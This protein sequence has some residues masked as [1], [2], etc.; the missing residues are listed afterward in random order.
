[1]EATTGPLGQ[2]IGNAVGIA[3]AEKMLSAHFNT[4]N[5][6]IIDHYTYVLASDGDMMEGIS[7]EA[8]SLAGHLGLGKLLI[9]YDSNKITID[10]SID[11]S[12]TEDISR[13]FEAMH[14]HTDMVDGYALDDILQSINKAKEILDRPSLIILKTIIAKGAPSLAGK[15]KAHSSPLG[16]EEVKNTKKAMGIN[17]HSEFYIDQKAITYFS[18]KQNLWAAKYKEW[19]I[20]FEKWKKEYPL[21]YAEWEKYYKAPDLMSV[22]FPVFKIGVKLSVRAASG[23]VLNALAQKIPNMIGGSADLGNATVTILEEF[24][25]FQK[26]NFKGRNIRFGV[27]EHAMGAI[28]NGIALYDGLIPFCGTL[29]VFSDY[30]RHTVRLASMMKLHVIYIYTH[31]SIFVGE[32]GPTHQPIEHITALRLIPGLIVLRPADAQ[33][34]LYAWQY[35][36]KHT[37][38]PVSLILA[39]Q[40]IEVFKKDD[41]SWKINLKR[42]AYVVSDCDG[43]PEIVIIASGSEVILALQAKKNLKN[44]KLRIVSMISRELFLSQPEEFKNRIIPTT[45]ATIIVEAGVATGWEQFNNNGC[46]LSVDRFGASGPGEEV[47]EYL[48]ISSDAIIRKIEEVRSK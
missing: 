15:H 22:K 16:K 20:K 4:N 44:S 12:F 33:E 8:A 43:E 11:L 5:Y 19:N 9:F 14:W 10:G 37:G 30:M 40:E 23:M 18:E 2:G 27:R 17:E 31:D 6:K 42:G 28:C 24:E 41:T 13:R 3:M 47:G 32:D 26:D 36:I 35:A 46:I 29:L 45:A 48:D 34:T 7:Y 39:R 1:V 25:D 21:L 38:G